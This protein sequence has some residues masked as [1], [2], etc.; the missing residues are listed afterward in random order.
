MKSLFR[1]FTIV[2]FLC[3]LAAFSQSEEGVVPFG[4]E[5]RALAA[6]RNTDEWLLHGRT[7][8]GQ[9]HSLLSQITTENIDRLGLSWYLDL[10]GD[11]GLQATPLMVDDVLYFTAAWSRV[12]AA[13][14][15]TGELLWSFDPQVD[16]S[17][18]V[19]CGPSNRGVAFWDGRVYVG[20]LDGRLI[21]LDAGTGKVIWSTQTVDQPNSPEAPKPK[22]TITG[23]PLVAGGKVFIGNG[24]AEFGVRGYVSAYDAKTGEQ[25]WRFYTIPGDPGKPFE[26]PILEM[27]AKTWHGEWWKYGGG[28]TAYDALSYDPE[29]NLFYIG[30]GNSGPYNPL[31]RTEGKGDNLFV[32]SIVA[33]NADTGEYV[34]HYQTTPGDSWDYTATQNMI[35]AD[36]E[37]EGK[38][39]KVLMQAPKNGFFY[40]L[41][42]KTGEFISAR[43]FEKVTWASGFNAKGRPQIND[44]ARYW[45][46]AEPAV[47]YPSALGA[48]NWYPMAYNPDVGLVYIPATSMPQRFVAQNEKD[49]SMTVRGR[50]TGVAYADSLAP[51]NP[52]VVEKVRPMFKGSL[53]AWD[54]RLQKP[55]WKIDY[56]TIGQGGVLSTAGN[57]IF[58]GL[59]GNQLVAY[60][61]TTGERVWSYDTQTPV[62]AG[63]ISYQVGGEQYIAVMA[64]RGGSIGRVA[65]RLY[66]KSVVNRPRL[67]VFK[68]GG[69]A[70]LPEPDDTVLTLLDVEHIEVDE[71]RVKHGAKLYGKYCSF[72]HGVNAYGNSINPDLRYSGFILSQEAFDQVVLGGA[73]ASRGMVSFGDDFSKEDSAALREYIVFENQDSRKYGDTTRIG[74]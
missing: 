61:A 19:C 9:R 64:S 67:L 37:I 6:D 30:V 41:D 21:A 27:A 38:L 51:A 25:V 5:Q 54:P 72:C 4:F 40:V 68:L 56:D 49:F 23:A 10:P 73:L 8:N 20:A 65:G 24:G 28:G 43:P 31:I 17:I 47:V 55:R 45:L 42:R 18:E 2:L 52:E 39:R 70:S 22:Y 44:S 12:Y 32:A 26:N 63:G 71:S 36:L 46:S 35:L 7:Y 11:G 50:N 48:H 69:D 58:Q 15:G 34:W 57:L 74:R 33:V 53:V 60:N 1:P 66:D 59:V 16:R 3:G 62:V 13:D 14:A 29:L